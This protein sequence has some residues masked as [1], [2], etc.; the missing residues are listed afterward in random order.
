MQRHG[1]SGVVPPR[2]VVIPPPGAP[3]PTPAAVPHAVRAR[4]FQ[5]ATQGALA[6]GAVAL[7]VAS[8]LCSL[9]VSW[10][11]LRTPK[12]RRS[13]TAKLVFYLAS[14]SAALALSSAASEMGTATAC[15]AP[16]HT[17]RREHTAAWALLESTRIWLLRCS[18]AWSAAVACHL[19]GERLRASKLLSYNFVTWQQAYHFCC[20]VGPAAH[21]QG[22][23]L[24][25][26]WLGTRAASVALYAGDAIVLLVRHAPILPSFL[27]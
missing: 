6:A 13:G 14:A 5:P 27:L 24:L 12:A 2:R 23:S 17:C 4:S 21:M 1:V 26:D 18:S 22:C 15:F 20:W 3:T 19:V 9:A 11:Y 25:N 7:N 8:L 16:P 10:L